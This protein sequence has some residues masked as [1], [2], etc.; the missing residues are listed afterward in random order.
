[1]AEKKNITILQM[2]DTHGYME[3]HW[4]HFWD[5]AYAKHIRAGGYPRMKTYIDQVR[6]EKNGNVLLLD[7]GDTFHGT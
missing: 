6:K 3:E 1:M 5:G 4:E 7:G 2:N